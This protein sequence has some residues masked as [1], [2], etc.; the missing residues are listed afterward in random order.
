MW[1]RDRGGQRKKKEK[2]IEYYE[3]ES[4]VSETIKEKEDEGSRIDGAA[5]KRDCDYHQ[6]KIFTK[7]F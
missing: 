5:V 7:R 1:D 6:S 2:K 3:D 4:S